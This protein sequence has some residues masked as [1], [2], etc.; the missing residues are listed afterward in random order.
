MGSSDLP[1]S[2]EARTQRVA[3][4]A[5]LPNDMVWRQAHSAPSLEG[6][7]LSWIVADVTFSVSGL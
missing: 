7:L 5:D 4:L 2:E 6:A 1:P 3:S